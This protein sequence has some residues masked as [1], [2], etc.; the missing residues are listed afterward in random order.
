[1]KIVP[2]NVKIAEEKY[3]RCDGDLQ[4]KEGPDIARK[5]LTEVGYNEEVTERVAFL[6]GH[7]HTYSGIDGM[8]YR[9]L[10]EADFLVNLYED[11]SPKSAVSAALSGVFETMTGKRICRRMFGV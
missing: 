10:V 1:M 9:I 4:E 6:V 2:L 5:L 3:G 7:H 8:D 11:G